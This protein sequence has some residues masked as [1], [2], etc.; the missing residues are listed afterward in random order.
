MSMAQHLQPPLPNMYSTSKSKRV[1]RM[2]IRFIVYKVVPQ[3]SAR[4]EAWR[5]ASY[6]TVRSPHQRGETRGTGTNDR[7]VSRRMQCRAFQ[8]GKHRHH[9]AASMRDTLREKRAGKFMRKG[10]ASRAGLRAQRVRV[11]GAE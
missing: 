10:T 3:R 4:A 7:G 11:R 9:V 8:T 6:A 5:E 2:H 1:E